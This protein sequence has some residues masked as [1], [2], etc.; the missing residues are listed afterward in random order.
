M[1]GEVASRWPGSWVIPDLP[2]HGR[3]DP[4]PRYS[5]GALA[6]AVAGCLDPGDPVMVLGHWVTTR[7]DADR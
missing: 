3:S 6:A 1:F 2:G 5:F 4:L 7:P